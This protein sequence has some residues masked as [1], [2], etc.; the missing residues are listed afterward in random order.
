[1]SLI[2]YAAAINPH[3]KSAPVAV[4]LVAVHRNGAI[5]SSVEFAPDVAPPLGN[6]TL[7]GAMQAEANRIVR[8][9]F[10][11]EQQLG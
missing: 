1:M 6:L 11:D 5:T 4:V 8:H 10:D 7:V 9:N 2:A 3:E